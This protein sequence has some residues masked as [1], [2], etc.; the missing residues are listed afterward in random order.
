MR[1]PDFLASPCFHASIKVSR[2]SLGSILYLLAKHRIESRTRS[3]LNPLLPNKPPIAFIAE[4]QQESRF[5]TTIEMN[6]NKAR[7]KSTRKKRGH[8]EPNNNRW[9]ILFIR[10]GLTNGEKRYN[11][12]SAI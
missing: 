5:Y 7:G 1:Y 11:E 2:S 12:L 6:L 3:S 8:S 9:N 10:N 4:K